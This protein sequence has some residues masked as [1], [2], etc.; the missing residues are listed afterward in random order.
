MIKIAFV[1]ISATFMIAASNESIKK[2]GANL[3]KPT[4]SQKST[5]AGLRLFNKD[6]E[7]VAE[8]KSIDYDSADDMKLSGCKIAPEKSIDDVMSAWARVYKNKPQQ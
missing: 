5:V 6:G 1:A 3:W 2:S 4:L 8:C 7:L